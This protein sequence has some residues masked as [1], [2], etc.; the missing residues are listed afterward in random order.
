MPSLETDLLIV[1]TINC[2]ENCYAAVASNT[3]DFMIDLP[4]TT[5]I[6]V[7]NLSYDV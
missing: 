4:T 3:G 2:Q 7:G 6:K 5:T 1:D